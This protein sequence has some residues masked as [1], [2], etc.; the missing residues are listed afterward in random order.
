MKANKPKLTKA[1][2]DAVKAYEY[3]L[4][5]EDRYLGSVFVTPMGQR[6]IEAKTKAAHDRADALGVGY[7]C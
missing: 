4:Q 6:E 3:C 5:Q 7:L 1:Q 2:R